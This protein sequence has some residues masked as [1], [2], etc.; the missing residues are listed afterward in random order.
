MPPK[1][2]TSSPSIMG[3]DPKDWD[4]G[5]PFPVS[6]NLEKRPALITDGGRHTAQ[7]WAAH[8]AEWFL[9]PRA[10]TRWAATDA[11][12]AP[13]VALAREVLE[14]VFAGVLA[15]E[16]AE[17]AA[18]GGSRLD[19]QIDRAAEAVATANAI[20]AAAAGTSCEDYWS[21]PDLPRLVAIEIAH[22]L[23]SADFVERAWWA[24][25]HPLN[26]AAV[27]F[28]ARHYPTGD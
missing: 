3:F 1:P 5:H 23:R 9:S 22:H 27:A 21:R 13:F 7:A 11:D 4:H 20:I 12:R 25:E 2:R 18:E 19:A 16:R 8:V 14:P 28:R 6:L 24:A 17:L 10:G 26:N 15:D